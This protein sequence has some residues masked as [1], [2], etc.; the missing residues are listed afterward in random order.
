MN[1]LLADSTAKSLCSTM[2]KLRHPP[3]PYMY[4]YWVAETQL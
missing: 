4:M 2:H 1:F 3:I